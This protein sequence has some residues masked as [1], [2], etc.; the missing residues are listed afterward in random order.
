M[1]VIELLFFCIGLLTKRIVVGDV[2]LFTIFRAFDENTKAKLKCVKY[3]LH[4]LSYLPCARPY[5]FIFSSET[6]YM[7][8]GE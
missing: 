1:V 2:N 6:N 3:V 5:R 8:L 4:E 7:T